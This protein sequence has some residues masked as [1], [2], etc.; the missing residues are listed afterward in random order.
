MQCCGVLHPYRACAN[1]NSKL[2]KIFLQ[3]NRFTTGHNSIFGAKLDLRKAVST[4]T[5]VIACHFLLVPLHT[6]AT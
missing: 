5:S 1:C 4:Q 2:C 6:I 3:S